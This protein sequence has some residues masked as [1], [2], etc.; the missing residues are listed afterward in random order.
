MAA[1]FALA[2]RYDNGQNVVQNFELAM[3]WYRKA[4][5]QGH[6][7]AQFNLALMYGFGHGCEIDLIEA[8]RWIDLAVANAVRNAEKYKHLFD[9]SVHR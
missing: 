2:L 8:S 5:E 4:A 3:A 6:P 7:R 9:T 1:Q